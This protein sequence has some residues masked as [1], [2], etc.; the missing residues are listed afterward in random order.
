MRAYGVRLAAR[1]AAWRGLWPPSRMQGGIRCRIWAPVQ[2]SSIPF[3]N[4]P[5]MCWTFRR[6]SMRSIIQTPTCCLLPG[7]LAPWRGRIWRFCWRKGRWPIPAM[8]RSRPR[9]AT[10]ATSASI[11]NSG[12]SSPTAAF[13]C[14]AKTG[15]GKSGLWSL[16]AIPFLPPPCLSPRPAPQ[17]K[18]RIR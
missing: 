12:K 1:S 9:K 3:W 15:T 6:R 17:G 2:A 13:A 10:T 14:P 8:E 7:S 16:P 18:S 5:G 4:M 11:P